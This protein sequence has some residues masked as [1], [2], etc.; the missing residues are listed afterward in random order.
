MTVLTCTREKELLQQLQSGRWPAASDP[1]LREHAAHCALCRDTIAVRSALQLSLAQSKAAAPLDSASLLWWR[2]QI[3]RRHAAVER[4]RRPITRAHRF[5]L[6]LNLLAVLA[7]VLWLERHR[8]LWHGWL[9]NSYPSALATSS[10]LRST[11]LLPFARSM[12][13][14]NL[15]LLIPCLAAV[16]LLGGVVVYLASDRS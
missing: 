1:E 10:P 7:S 14:W 2:A 6:A 16:A 5:A 12:L 13:S 4:V 11:T 15:T 3:R 8:D 9:S